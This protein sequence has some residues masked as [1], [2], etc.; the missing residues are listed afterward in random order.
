ME[1]SNPS[2]QRAWNQA[3]AHKLSLLLVLD[4]LL[5]QLGGSGG[6]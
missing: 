4:F 1:G 5:E 6:A 3:A 2:A